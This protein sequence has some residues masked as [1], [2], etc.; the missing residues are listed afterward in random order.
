VRFLGSTT[1]AACCG[2]TLSGSGRGIGGRLA[3]DLAA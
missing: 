1:P 2:S 3:F